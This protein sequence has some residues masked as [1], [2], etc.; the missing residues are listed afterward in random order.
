MTIEK[1]IEYYKSIGYTD[2]EITEELQ[3]EII[4]KLSTRTANALRRAGINTIKKLQDFYNN[5][6]GERSLLS[7]RLLGKK[8]VLEIITKC[9][10]EGIELNNTRCLYCGK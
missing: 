6:H 3:L 5:E 7:L 9:N 4:L 2:E 8:G 1:H 10:K